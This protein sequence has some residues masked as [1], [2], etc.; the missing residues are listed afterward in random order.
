MSVP[1]YLPG[2]SGLSKT[3]TCRLLLVL[4]TAI[5]LIAAAAQYSRHDLGEPQHSQGHCDLC[6]HLGCTAGSPAHASVPGKPVL[7]LG[8]LQAGHHFI[9]SSRPSAGTSLPRGPPHSN[10]LT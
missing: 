6:S 1:L 10:D 2:L 8:S 5:A 4:L 7:G 9:L 3:H